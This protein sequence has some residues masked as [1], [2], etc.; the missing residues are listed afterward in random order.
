MNS[1][2]SLSQKIL[3]VTALLAASGCSKE[4]AAPVTAPSNST[5]LVEQSAIDSPAAKVDEF[6][7]SFAPGG[8]AATYLA[9]FIDDRIKTIQETRK[10]AEGAD[11]RSGEYEFHGARLMKYHGA[12]LGSADMLQLEFDEQGKVLVAHAG[13]NA[14][15]AE[16]I[17]KI[18]DRAQS[19]RSHAVA[20][21][22]LRGH[23]QRGHDRI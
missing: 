22:A 7:G 4:A 9:T 14:A 23:D 17:T 10:A 16:E 18:R 13:A 2:G 3:L 19:L 5:P 12:A 15:S 8:I 21:R 6:R 1:L 11:E 20:Q